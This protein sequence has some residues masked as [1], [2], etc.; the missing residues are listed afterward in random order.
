MQL[1]QS[2]IPNIEFESPFYSNFSSNVSPGNLHL[3]FSVTFYALY[4]QQKLRL[5]NATY[6]TPFNLILSARLIVLLVFSVVNIR[7]I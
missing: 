5:D 6:L 7:N 2:L 3:L 1:N 4:V